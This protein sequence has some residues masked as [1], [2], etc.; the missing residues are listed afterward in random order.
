MAS[1]NNPQEAID[2]A[3]LRDFALGLVNEELPQDSMVF[4]LTITD[5]LNDLVAGKDICTHRPGAAMNQFTV[6]QGV[7]AGLAAVRLLD[8]IFRFSVEAVKTYQQFTLE[9]K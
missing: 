8:A 9:Q 2:S 5:L 6:E 1:T 4:E 3:K 7:N